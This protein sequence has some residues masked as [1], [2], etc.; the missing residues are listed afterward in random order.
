M[1]TQRQQ[2]ENKER[3]EYKEKRFPSPTAYTDS[4]HKEEEPH[5]QEID[6]WRTTG[7]LGKTDLSARWEMDKEG[8]TGAEKYLE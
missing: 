5:G 7:L 2:R 4:R 6:Q 8:S 1:K 3:S